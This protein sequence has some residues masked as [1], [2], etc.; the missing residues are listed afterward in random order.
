[1]K[2]TTTLDDHFKT[3]KYRKYVFISIN[4]IGLWTVL[5]LIYYKM[6]FHHISPDANII[7]AGISVS[8]AALTKLSLI[9][10]M[11]NLTFLLG[12]FFY[13]YFKNPDKL[14]G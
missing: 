11:I 12:Y 10:Q 13:N 3:Y 1:M 2:T 4:T 8:F 5:L 9:L 7:E 14:K 6:G